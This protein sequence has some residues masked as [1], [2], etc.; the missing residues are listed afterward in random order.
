MFL[1]QLQQDSSSD[2]WSEAFKSSTD[3]EIVSNYDFCQLCFEKYPPT[4]KPIKKSWI[5]CDVCN[6]WYHKNCLKIRKFLKISGRF[7]SNTR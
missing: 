2:E 3:A 6:K 4:K 7:A 1:Q 5:Q